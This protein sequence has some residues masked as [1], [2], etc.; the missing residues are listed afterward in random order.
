MLL[1]HASTLACGMSCILRLA[2]EKDLEQICEVFEEHAGIPAQRGAYWQHLRTADPEFPH[3][4]VVAE[5]EARVIAF[6][7]RCHDIVKIL[8]RRPAVIYKGSGAIVLKAL[9][10][11]IRDDKW[12]SVQLRADLINGVGNLSKLIRFYLDQG[13]SCPG[14]YTMKKSLVRTG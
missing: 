3:Q 8:V 13:Y 5:S 4:Y 12:D 11:L 7:S 1:P 6:G 14:G 2:S 9:E 10:R